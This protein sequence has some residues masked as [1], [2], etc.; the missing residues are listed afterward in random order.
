MDL[1]ATDKL[2][3]LRRVD[4]FKLG[5][6]NA[7]DN[8]KLRLEKPPRVDKLSGYSKDEMGLGQIPWPSLIKPLVRRS[9]EKVYLKK[10]VA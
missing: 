6:A 2:L 7:P 9:Q 5:S 10:P 1:L 3:T 4:V 8:C